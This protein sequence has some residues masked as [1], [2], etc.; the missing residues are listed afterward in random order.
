MMYLLLTMVAMFIIAIVAILI[1]SYIDISN[2]KRTINPD[3]TTTVEFGYN[4]KENSMNI[5]DFAAMVAEKEGGKKE[6]SIAQIKEVMKVINR[7]VD[8]GLYKLIRN[9]K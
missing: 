5:K 4:K 3:G 6:V 2:T 8:G 9:I 7:L 1:Q